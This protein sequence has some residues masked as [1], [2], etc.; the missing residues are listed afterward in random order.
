M[1]KA[2]FTL[3]PFGMDPD[4]T[5]FQ[6]SG[7]IRRQR[8]MLTLHYRLQGPLAEL[9]IPTLT[10]TPLR[11]NH[12]WKKTC[13]ECFI[14][15]AELSNYWEINLAPAGHWNIYHFNDY[16]KGMREKPAYKTLPMRAHARADVFEI[17]CDIDLAPI[18]L[19]RRPIRTALSAI[20]MKKDGDL[21]Y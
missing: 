6:I 20:V 14:G 1:E 4:R 17:R 21:I 12:L 9:E 15:T 19:S 13:F 3:S 5:G 2:E 7:Q 16:R 18:G 11:R 10:T 8:R